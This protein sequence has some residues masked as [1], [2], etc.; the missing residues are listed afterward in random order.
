MLVLNY[1]LTTFNQPERGAYGNVINKFMSPLGNSTVSAGH[2]LVLETE[3]L[4]SSDIFLTAIAMARK[5][6]EK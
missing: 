5:E 2:N 3:V 1:N 4:I 6:A